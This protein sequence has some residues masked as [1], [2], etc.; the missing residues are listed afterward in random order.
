EREWVRFCEEVLDRP[1][2]V[3]DARFRENASRVTHRDELD[4]QIQ[5]CFSSLSHDQVVQ[6]LDQAGIAYAQLNT[7]EDMWNHPQLRA[8][9]RW[10]TVQTENGPIEA[11]LPPFN[12]SG[13]TPQMGPVPK[14]GE[15][16]ETML[17]ELG[18]SA[19]TIAQL[20]RLKII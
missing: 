10:S 6:R 12:V 17:Q 4:A 18:Y 20:R 9:H 14:L 3:T 7:M 8:R 19:Q 11:L 13:V 1:D 15:H 5:E 2:W 16:T